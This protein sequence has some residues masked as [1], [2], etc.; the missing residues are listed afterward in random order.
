[1]LQDML[2]K[3]ALVWQVIMF[4][5]YKPK[6]KKSS[7]YNLQLSF[8]KCLWDVT[9]KAYKPDKQALQNIDM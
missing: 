5:F 8:F 4:L 2:Q 3:L 1:M 9:P 7:H 6:P